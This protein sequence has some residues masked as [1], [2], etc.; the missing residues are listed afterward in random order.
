M[1][2]GCFKVV[3]VLENERKWIMLDCKEM[4]K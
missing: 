1:I 3:K 2:A 4:M